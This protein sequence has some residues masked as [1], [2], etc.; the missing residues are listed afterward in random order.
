M[1]YD[2]ESKIYSSPSTYGFQIQE[3]DG[4]IKILQ[5][6]GDSE[7]HQI[8]LSQEEAKEVAKALVELADSMA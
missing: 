2:Q 7:P 4:T 3:D 8:Y 6:T 1:K 5:E